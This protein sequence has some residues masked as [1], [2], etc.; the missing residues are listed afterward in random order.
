VTAVPSSS[1]SPSSRSGFHTTGFPPPPKSVR[2]WA[3]PTGRGADALGEK[4]AGRSAPPCAKC[5][6][7]PSLLIL[8]RITLALVA[9]SACVGLVWLLNHVS[10]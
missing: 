3:V 1:P 2:L 10:R 4:L 9:I 6:S 7:P 5:G 8:A